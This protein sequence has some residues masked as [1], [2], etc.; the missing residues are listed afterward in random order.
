MPI[1][2]VWLYMFKCDVCVL[3]HMWIKLKRFLITLFVFGSVFYHSL[4]LSFVLKI[5]F[6]N[7]SSLFLCWK[8]GVRGF[9]ESFATWLRVTKLKNAYLAFLVIKQWV[10]QVARESL[11]SWPLGKWPDQLF[12]GNFV[13]FW[14]K[15]PHMTPSSPNPLFQ[16]FYIKTQLLSIVLHSINISK[17]IFNTFNWF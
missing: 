5:L 2:F 17:I 1:S 11:A 6:F 9:C 16:S 14:S 8:T 4:S 13:S 3:N 10:S 12:H 7:V 15:T